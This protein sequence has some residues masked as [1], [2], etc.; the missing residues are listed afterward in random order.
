MTALPWI[1]IFLAAPAAWSRQLR[2]IGLG[3]LALGYGAALTAGQLT[4]AAALTV[5]PLALAAWAVQPSRPLALRAGGHAAFIAI[6]VALILHAMPGFHNPRVIEAQRLTP[7]AVPFSMYLNLDKP[8]IAFW[9]LWVLPW[10]RAVRSWRATTAAACGA[11]ALTAAACLPLAM[12]L[13]MVAWAPKWPAFA[14]LWLLNQLLLVTIAE[15]A[16]FRGYLQG[17]LQRL[18]CRQ[19][20]PSALGDAV[21]IAVA[22]TL[23]ALLHFPGG[24][25]W[26]VL[27]GVTGVGYGLAYRFGGLAAAVLAHVGLNSLHFFLFT[28]PMLDAAAAQ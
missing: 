2:G 28:Y 13:Q 22:A 21:S 5:A 3:L 6:A 11:L 19:G 16:L 8:L 9:L 23:F 20:V 27:A 25:P 10:V 12:A 1:A 15:E 17:G 4:P 7:D 26:M 24:L 18:L 14:W